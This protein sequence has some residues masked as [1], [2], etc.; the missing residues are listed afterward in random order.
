MKL[1][2]E[3]QTDILKGIGI[4]MMIAGY[5]G[6][7]SSLRIDVYVGAFYM[8]MFFFVSGYFL[9]IEKYTVGNYLYRKVK[10]LLIPYVIWSFFHLTLWLLARKAGV[11]LGGIRRC[12][13]RYY[14]G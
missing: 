12:L 1:F 5:T 3:E 14:L 10:Q 9:Q 6:L 11:S 8:P 13:Q 2:R 4:I 7:L